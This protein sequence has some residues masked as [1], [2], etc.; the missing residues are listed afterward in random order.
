MRRLLTLSLAVAFTLALAS[1][2]H[3]KPKKQELC[4]YKERDGSVRQTRSRDDVP[5]IYK[6]DAKC[7][8][9]ANDSL[10]KPEEMQLKGNIRT[11]TISSNLGPVWMSWERES[12][13]QFGRTP[14]RAVTDAANTISKALKNN[15]F[16]IKIQTLSVPWKIVFLGGSLDA[17]K[18]PAQLVQNCHPGWMTPP[19]NIYIAADRVAGGCG[20]AHSS[21][22]IADSTLTEV[23]LHE[24]GHVIEFYLL[25][26]Q[27]IGDRMRAEGFAT[28][29][30]TYAAEFSSIVNKRTIYNMHL[31]TAKLSFRQNPKNFSFQGTAEDYA[32]ASLIFHA[33]VEERGMSG[34]V[35][36]YKVMAKERLMLFPA[37]E[38][39]LG[40][41]QE[42]L[43]TEVLKLV[44]LK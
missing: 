35:E 44:G 43:Q 26:R 6:G 1:D 42:Q 33:I 31:A 41:N 2:A 9:V 27:F 22:S 8:E 21:A 11:E 38:K 3:A 14:L 36:V 25:D 39:A 32:R 24:M 4:V 15:A 34:L 5:R 28:W 19:A 7:F 16:P 37:V 17:S 30:E 12:E 29:F 13:R 23:L 10:A 20:P 40:W 18:I